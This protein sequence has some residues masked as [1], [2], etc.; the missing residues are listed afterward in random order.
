M[1]KCRVQRE[2]PVSVWEEVGQFAVARL[3]DWVYL[4]R[5][6]RAAHKAMHHPRVLSCCTVSFEDPACTRK[7]GDM[8]RMIKRAQIRKCTV[9]FDVDAYDVPDLTAMA[10]MPKLESLD[11]RGM[12]RY[13]TRV[14]ALPALTELK[15]QC[16]RLWEMSGLARWPTLTKLDLSEALDPDISILSRLPEL[17]VLKMSPHFDACYIRN[18]SGLRALTELDLSRCKLLKNEHLKFLAPLVQLRVLSL[19]HTNISDVSSLHPLVNLEKLDLSH[20]RVVYMESLLGFRLWPDGI[21]HVMFN[22]KD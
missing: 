7:I 13:L 22:G 2:L 21:L 5:V 17:A 12:M 16:P 6:N 1:K 14:P 4:Q 15:L 11:V 10:H 9:T 18:L 3:S 20:T 19:A 8:S